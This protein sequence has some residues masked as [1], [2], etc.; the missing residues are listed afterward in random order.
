MVGK[1]T[2]VAKPPGSDTHKENTSFKFSPQFFYLMSDLT[3]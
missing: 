3:F 2:E 1:S